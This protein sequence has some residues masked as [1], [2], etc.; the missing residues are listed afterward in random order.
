M[1]KRAENPYPLGPHIPIYSS[2]EVVL[3]PSPSGGRCYPF[4]FRW[5][6]RRAYCCRGGEGSLTPRPKEILKLFRM[7]LLLLH[8]GQVRILKYLCKLQLL[9]Q[10]QTITTASFVS[11][12]TGF[13]ERF[14]H[15]SQL[16]EVHRAFEASIERFNIFS[17]RLLPKGAALTMLVTRQKLFCHRNDIMM[18]QVIYIALNCRLW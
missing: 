6:A 12:S 17:I 2:Y 16:K 13:N 11:K 8:R 3:P 9:F 14:A 10:R 4:N 5:W 1:T 15:A 7:W 18:F